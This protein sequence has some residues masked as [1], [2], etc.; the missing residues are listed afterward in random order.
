[1][2]VVDGRAAVADQPLPSTEAIGAAALTWAAALLCAGLAAAEPVVVPETVTAGSW[3]LVRMAVEDAPV[4][5]TV[6][7]LDRS[8]PMFPEPTG[9][10]RA[11]VPVPL[12]TPPGRYTLTVRAKGET[13]K[14]RVR[15]AGRP[16]ERMRRLQGLVVDA[17]MAGS[18]RGDNRVMHRAIRE[19]TPRAR[20]SGPLRRPL[21]G[22]VSATYGQRRR[23]GG[24]AEWLH[25]GVDF[26][27]PSAWPVVAVAPGRV[28]LARRMSALGN[29]ITID[30]GQGVMTA[31]LHLLRRV[32]EVGDEVE[33][34]QVIGTVGDTGLSQ[35]AHLHLSAYI[36]SVA[37]DPLEMLEKG[38]PY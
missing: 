29:T 2:R 8:F 9:R 5:G 13:G 20:W 25:R 31:Y 35:G 6:R 30:H 10:L 18:L 33:Q 3:A 26:A 32:V 12:D 15:V 21:S 27:M 16:W 7:F 36:H 1:M 17:E 4:G 22:R 24:G 23:Y 38:L 34:G 28:V 14:A 37:V 11:F 19:V